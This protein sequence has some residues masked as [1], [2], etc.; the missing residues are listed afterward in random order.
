VRL[1]VVDFRII[2][3]EVCYTKNNM[4]EQAKLN[5]P[6]LIAKL[7]LSNLNIMK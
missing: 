5:E 4:F 3:P 7:E 1:Y 6:N 2:A